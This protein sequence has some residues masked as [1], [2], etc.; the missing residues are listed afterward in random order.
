MKFCYACGRLTP[1]EPL[2]CNSCGKSYG[3]KLCPRLHV[4]PRSAE[5]CSQC[6]SRDLSNPGPRVPLW[7]RIL[8]IFLRAVLILLFIYVALLVLLAILKGI[9]ASRQAQD[10]LLCIGVLILILFWLWQEVPDWVRK[11]VRH[12]LGRKEQRRGR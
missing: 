12:V 5:V 7:S 2:F 6:A 10:A 1:G 4:N 8:E 9:L 3:V 11:L